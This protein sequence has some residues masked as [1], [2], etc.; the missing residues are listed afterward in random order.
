[1]IQR[2][3]NAGIS[4]TRRITFF[5]K[6]AFSFRKQNHCIKTKSA[7]LM[8]PEQSGLSQE[9]YDHHNHKDDDDDGDD[10]DDST[11]EQAGQCKCPQR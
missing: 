10:D 9:Q 4:R 6:G 2:V 8:S 5:F 1:M 7:H 3:L 11:W